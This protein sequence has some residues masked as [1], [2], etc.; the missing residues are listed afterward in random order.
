MLNCSD[1]EAK[2][3]N[4]GGLMDWVGGLQR[5]AYARFNGRTRK[6]SERLPIDGRLKSSS[7]SAFL[8]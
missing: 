2:K 5:R 7:A 4:T 8:V 6:I 3:G 1:S